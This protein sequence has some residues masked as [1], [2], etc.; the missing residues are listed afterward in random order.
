MKSK[1]TFLVLLNILCNL[2]FAQLNTIEGTVYIDVEG[3]R[4]ALHGANIYYEDRS[5]GV[6]TDENGKFKIGAPVDQSI[7]ISFVGFQP[8][9][10]WEFDNSPYEIL[11]LPVKI[12]DVIIEG[13][14]DGRDNESVDDI[15]K[16]GIAE[17]SRAACCN[18]S[19]SFETNATIDIAYS[20]AV[21]GAKEIKLL[22][23]AGR[24]SQILIENTPGLRGLSQAYGLTQVPGQWLDAIFV[25][26]GAGSVVNGYESLTGQINLEF[27]K[28]HKGDQLF[29]NGFVS[30]MGKI[31]INADASTNLS[32]KKPMLRT[33]AHYETMRRVVDNNNDGFMD[34]PR[35]DHINIY[36]RVKSKPRE[37]F[38]SQM[39]IGVLYEERDGGQHQDIVEGSPKLYLVDIVTNKIDWMAKT[40]FIFPEK[41]T[42]IGVTYRY[43]F[44]DIN[45]QF[46]N[47]YYDGRE[48]F[49]N[50]NVINDLELNEE[51]YLKTGVTYLFNGFDERFLGQEFDKKESVPGAYTELNYKI[52]DK[53]ELTPGMRIDHHNLFGFFYSPR[54]RVRYEP[55]RKLVIKAN[56]GKGYRAPNPYIENLKHLASSRVFNISNDLDAERSWNFGLN[57]GHEFFLRFNKVEVKVDAYHTRFQNQMVTDLENARVANIYNL[58]GQSFSNSIQ[59]DLKYE[60]GINYE[61]KLSYKRDDV[62]TTY[63]NGFQRAALVPKNRALAGFNYKSTNSKWNVHLTGN[64]TGQSRLPNTSTNPIE[65]RL[66]DYSD[67]FLTFNAQVNFRPDDSW[68]FYVGGE[69]LFNYQQPNAIIQS[70]D[71]FGPFFDTSLI[72]G[73]LGGTRLYLGIRYKL[74]KLKRD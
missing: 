14:P 34:M 7:I 63:I 44:N 16:I 46:G 26:R 70:E 65:F 6:S 22:G 23:L 38:M 49:A 25:S 54:V 11:L 66:E 39:G 10:I 59:A 57:V 9:K 12:D 64:W 8:Y 41:E 32:N 2:C 43:Y 60:I 18:L 69:N 24:Y 56:A 61:L 31:E 21:S 74:N 29:L 5:Q 36:T 51:L 58:N 27:K 3:E 30:N 72:Y 17:L 48:H 45:A 50:I 47:R 15:Y 71:P 55:A 1:W 73:P 28:P 68:D 4:Q 53:F 19:E 33:L 52:E 67:D 13:N 37:K 40:G 42:S 20:D 35:L 62:F